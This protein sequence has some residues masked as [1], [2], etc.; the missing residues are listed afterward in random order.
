MEKFAY[1][2]LGLGAVGGL[3]GM[4]SVL[5]PPRT[6]RYESAELERYARRKKIFARG[7]HTLSTSLAGLGLLLA[8]VASAF[9]ILVGV[10]LVRGLIEVGLTNWKPKIAPGRTGLAKDAKTRSKYRKDTQ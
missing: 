2:I 7:F 10:L 3:A 5:K 4:L 8:K 9:E 1:I 6:G